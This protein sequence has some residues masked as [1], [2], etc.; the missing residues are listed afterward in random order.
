MRYYIKSKVF[1]IK[2]DFWVKNDRGQ[3]TYFIDKEFFSF[4]LQFR[5]IENNNEIYKVREKLLKFM[6][7]YEIYDR[8]DNIIGT[9]KNSL[10]SLKIESSLKVIM[11]ILKLKEIF[12]IIVIEL[13]IMGEV[14]LSLIKNF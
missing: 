1:K 7:S 5:V 8:N 10:H 11:E 13:I 6:P 3:D 14:L 2:E 12:G 4:G 9:V